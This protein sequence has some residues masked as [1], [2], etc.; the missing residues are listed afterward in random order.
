MWIWNQCG[1]YDPEDFAARLML[2]LFMTLLVEG[3]S[4]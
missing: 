1:R 2:D 4:D 3:M